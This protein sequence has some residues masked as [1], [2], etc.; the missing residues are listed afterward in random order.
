MTTI[1]LDSIR[2]G[3]RLRNVDPRDAAFEALKADIK[4]HGVIQPIVL[5]RMASHHRPRLTAGLHRLT[6]LRDLG[7]TTLSE[8]REYVWLDVSGLTPRQAVLK[9]MAAETAENLRRVQLSAR[10]R[11]LFVA[12]AERVAVRTVIER[13]REEQRRREA[14]KR[15]ADEAAAAARKRA[16]DT[17]TA[18]AKAEA[19]RAETTRKAADMAA[20]RGRET[21]AT[22]GTP[23]SVRNVAS[24]LPKGVIDEMVGIT[25]LGKREVQNVSRETRNLYAFLAP[26]ALEAHAICKHIDNTPGEYAILEWMAQP[27]QRAYHDGLREWSARVIAKQ[28]VDMPSVLRDNIKRTNAAAAAEARLKSEKLARAE[29]VK[30]VTQLASSVSRAIEQMQEIVATSQHPSVAGLHREER[31]HLDRLRALAQDIR[32]RT[33]TRAAMQ[34]TGIN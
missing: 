24:P 28:G 3:R 27:G 12:R 1:P 9:H 2:I 8:G 20:K 34:A 7:H 32:Q 23:T 31:V 5:F 14:D 16:R 6:A 25:G 13:R 4:Q 21:L 17:K 29:Y 30:V 11:K 15:A 33:S 26:E 18:E 22:L 10:Q 19:E